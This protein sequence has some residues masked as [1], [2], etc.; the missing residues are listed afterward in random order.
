MRLLSM[1]RL[2]SERTIVVH[3]RF[4]AEAGAYC[5]LLTAAAAPCHTRATVPGAW[6]TGGTGARLFGPCLL[7]SF[8]VPES[9]LFMI[10]QP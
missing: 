1:V 5:I 8:A 7:V 10:L 9:G 6:L 3:G 4:G 2:E